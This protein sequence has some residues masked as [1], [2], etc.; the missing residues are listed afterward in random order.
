[1]SRV[2]QFEGGP[3]AGEETSVPDDYSAQVIGLMAYGGG[4]IKRPGTDVFF[5]R[6]VDEPLRVT[7]H[8]SWRPIVFALLLS[9]ALI[10]CVALVFAPLHL[11]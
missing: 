3:W 6:L 1:M 5:W 10:A 9:L 4:Y 8:M 2:V 7:T 11:P